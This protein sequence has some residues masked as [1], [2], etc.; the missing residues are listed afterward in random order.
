[1]KKEP[2]FK[3]RDLV[4][5]ELTH[6]HIPLCRVVKIEGNRVTV[7]FMEAVKDSNFNYSEGE[8]MSMCETSK[9]SHWEKIS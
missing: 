9:L 7:K 8:T 5:F 6:E 4:L 2:E 3:V 1:M